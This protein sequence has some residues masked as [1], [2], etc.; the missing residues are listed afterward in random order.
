M[1][2]PGKR[3]RVLI[4]DDSAFARLMIAR[5]VS[6]DPEIEIAGVARNGIDAIEK[7]QSLK[8]DVVTLDIEM[9]TMDGIAALE[10]IMSDFP[11][12]VV[13]LSSLTTEGADVTVKALEIGAVDFFLKPSLISPTGSGESNDELINKIK[14]AAKVDVARITSRPLRINQGLQR[15]MTKKLQA[16]VSR[17]AKLNHV[18]IIGAST[19]G[20]RALYEVVPNIPEDI[21]AAILIV[22][23]IPAI[24]SE[25]PLSRRAGVQTGPVC[26][27]LARRR[28][29]YSP[30][31]R[32]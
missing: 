30:D 10:R 18:V 20:P 12:P 3:I 32:G 19:G 24:F 4:V 29:A 16:P 31:H 25:S 7:I 13:M 21:P 17:N 1:I 27:T 22:Q 9:P 23:H 11:T 28:I 2:F 14:Q 6:V 5:H 8:P 26:R 15:S